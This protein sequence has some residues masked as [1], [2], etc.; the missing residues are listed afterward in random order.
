MLYGRVIIKEDEVELT[1]IRAQGAGGQH[2]NKVSS[3]I[4]LRFDIRASS[5]PDCQQQRL[6]AYRDKRISK[7]GDI[8]IKAQQY[9]SQDQNRR[10]ALQRLQALVEQALIVKPARRKTTV[11]RAAKQRRLDNKT[12]RSKLKSLRSKVSTHNY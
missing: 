12:Q 11:S 8:I 2:V 1:A 10:D 7:D 4:H 5:L 9:R 6:L 3:A